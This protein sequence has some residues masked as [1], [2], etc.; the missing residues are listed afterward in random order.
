MDGDLVDV[1]ERG[2][3]PFGVAAVEQVQDEIPAAVGQAQDAIPDIRDADICGGRNG[4]RRAE[5]FIPS[6]CREVPGLVPHSGIEEGFRTV[7]GLE[8]QMK[9][10]DRL[11]GGIFRVL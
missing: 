1:L 2:E 10:Q 4:L 11:L 5:R 3:F 7:H 6:F 8:V 9:A